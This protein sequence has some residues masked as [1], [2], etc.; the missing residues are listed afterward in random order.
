MELEQKKH[1][2]KLVEPAGVF[3]YHIDDPILDQ[4]EDETDEAWGRRMLKA[5]RMDGLVNAD[6]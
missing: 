5:L 3:Y 4:E 6:R 1:P 2:G